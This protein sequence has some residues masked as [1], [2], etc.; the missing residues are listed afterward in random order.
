MA[1]TFWHPLNLHSLTHTMTLHRCDS[2]CICLLFFFDSMNSTFDFRICC[3]FHHSFNTHSSRWINNWVFW[4]FVGCI[5]A[6]P[7]QHSIRVHINFVNALAVVY[8]CMCVYINNL[9]I[10]YFVSFIND[11]SRFLFIKNPIHLTGCT[12]FF[13]PLQ[14]R[15]NSISVVRWIFF[16]SGLLCM[17]YRSMI[18]E[19]KK[20]WMNIERERVGQKNTNVWLF[21]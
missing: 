14:F 4:T 18:K 21:S 5:F 8:S 20:K 19:L 11:H 17:N 9:T 13:S 7:S 16:V 2:M 3:S 6:T 10:I 1:N 12:L 15:L